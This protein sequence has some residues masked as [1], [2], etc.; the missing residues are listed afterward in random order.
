[1]WSSGGE[2]SARMI[3]DNY[4]GGGGGARGIFFRGGGGGGGG[5]GDFFSW[6]FDRR[7]GGLCRGLLRGMMAMLKDCFLFLSYCVRVG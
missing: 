1:M 6:G 4:C 5:P 7:I 3:C 2:G